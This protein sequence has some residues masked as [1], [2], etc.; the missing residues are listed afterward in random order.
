MG[1][2]EGVAVE[3]SRTHGE[4][5]DPDELASYVDD[6]NRSRLLD[7]DERA[8]HGLDRRGV[9][10]APDRHADARPETLLLAP[11]VAAADADEPVAVVE[12]EH[13]TVAA[14]LVWPAFARVGGVRSELDRL[15]STERAGQEPELPCVVAAVEDPSGAGP[16]DRGRRCRFRS[17]LRDRDAES[18]SA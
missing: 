14:H 9:R 5:E 13:V 1:D 2:H 15:R 4:R 17:T 12:D 16:G 7:R 3:A 6:G 18:R 10:A 8:G 11:L